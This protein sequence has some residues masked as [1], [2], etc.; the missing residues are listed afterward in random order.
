MKV[1]RIKYIYKI[2][3]AVL[4]LTI[5]SCTKNFES[6]NTHPYN[7]TENELTNF[8]K[9]GNLFPTLISTMHFSQENKSQF[10]EQMVFG[11]FGGYF[12]TTNNWQGTNFGT[13][14]PALDWVEVPFK[15]IMVNFSSNYI[16]VKSTT[17]ST[18]YIY[19]WA[20]I[21]RVAAMLRVVDTYGP[22]PYSKIGVTDDDKVPFDDVK[23]IYHQ[24]FEELD[25]S[26][27]VLNRFVIGSNDYKV[28]PMAMY[29]AVYNGDFAKWIKFA[30]SLKMRM[31]IRISTVDPEFAKAKFIEALVG[32]P[33]DLNIDNAFIPTQDNPYYK[34][35]ASWNDLAIN[36]MLSSFMNGYIDPRRE[37]Y[38]T[39]VTGNTY[40]GVRMGI[41]NINQS[42]YSNPNNY[43]K[44]AFT[45]TTP[46]LIF[47]AAETAFLNAEATL[48]GWITGGDAVA[49]SYYEQGI[50]LS[51]NEHNVVIGTYLTGT[52][53]PQNYTN[54]SL[55][56]ANLNIP[57]RI[58][59]SWTDFG[60]PSNSKLEK[61]ITQK[62][63]ANFPYGSE[64][65]ADHRRT[66]FPQIF[67][68]L[69]NLSST[70][71]VGTIDNNFGKL[72]RRLPYPQ[73]QYQNNTENVQLGVTFLDGDD[74]ASTNLW[75]AKK[76]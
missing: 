27:A 65:W 21:I 71:S 55:S 69:D 57:N 14:N 49:K 2:V 70:A 40:R 11:Q 10:S 39:V 41:Q 5:S 18:G 53:V 32:G 66:G 4:A 48:L 20:N 45:S 59:V 3:F 54:P 34:A 60:N 15:D 43:S 52:T 42:T 58:T 28:N 74:V 64:A 63:L 9:L 76:N 24:M 61:I 16:K 46:L 26:I 72:I 17:K 68:A 67:P 7:P 22:I 56:R 35:S 62:W 47:N 12:A 29:D 1:V 25:E 37:K 31:A 36:A 30:N 38:M 8:E 19:A 50:Q 23:N 13:F 51:M 75:W 73:S 44:P 33:I 6:Y